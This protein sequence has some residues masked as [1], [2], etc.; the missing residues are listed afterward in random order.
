MTT[1]SS[2]R[3]NQLDIGL[4]VLRVIAGT[5]WCAHGLQKL[6]VFGLAGT[7]AGMEQ[8]GAPLPGLTAPL[9]MFV[10]IVC[11]I[12][13]IL[14]LFARWAAIPLAI[15]MLSATLIVHVKNGFFNPMG[16]E[17]TLTL[18]GC[19]VAIALAGPGAYSVDGILARRK[20]QIGR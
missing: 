8:M 1:E 11:G 10:Q 12:A 13:V 20:E 17:L 2:A 6:F 16:V 5:V 7:I 19:A 9:V 4:T 18:F 14:G 3:V 15:D